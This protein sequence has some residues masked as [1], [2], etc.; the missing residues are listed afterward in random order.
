ME[1]GLHRARR[2]AQDVGDFVHGTLREVTENHA[3]ALGV[4]EG[5]DRVAEA[6][7]RII[8]R[9]RP[10][11]RLHVGDIPTIFRGEAEP[12]LVAASVIA[13]GIHN[14]ACEVRTWLI[15][16]ATFVTKGAFKHILDDFFRP[17]LVSKQ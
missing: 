3:F 1:M 11:G 5:I 9:C 4:R 6:L 14:G 13:A 10:L 17:S 7:V 16:D 8:S 15:A 2:N 12:A